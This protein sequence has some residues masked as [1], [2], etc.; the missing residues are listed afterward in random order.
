MPGR[1]STRAS[2]S[3]PSPR[4]SWA[5]RPSNALRWKIAAPRSWTGRQVGQDR[6]GG[7]ERDRALLPDEPERTG[8]AQPQALEPREPAAQHLELHQHRAATSLE[9]NADPPVVLEPDQRRRLERDLGA[10][11]AAVD[12]HG[13]RAVAHLADIG[14]AGKVDPGRRSPSAAHARRS[15]TAA[16]PPAATPA[17]GTSAP[18]RP[19]RRPAPP[20]PRRRSQPRRIGSDRSTR[21][22]DRL[23]DH[24][25]RSPRPCGR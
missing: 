9:R 22:L 7:L 8:P 6:K 1:N 15:R 18:A 21:R 20:V 16:A 17:P 3:E 2:K 5:I 12:Q 13:H 10:A 19:P 14:V 24:A 25:S 4:I 11:R 23:D